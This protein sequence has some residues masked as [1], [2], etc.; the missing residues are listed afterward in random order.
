[1]CEPFVSI[2]SLEHTPFT[3]WTDEKVIAWCGQITE[4]VPKIARRIEFDALS[5]TTILPAAVD[6]EETSFKMRHVALADPEIIDKLPHALFNL[7]INYP[8]IIRAIGRDAARFAGVGDESGA[9]ALNNSN[10]RRV[11]AFATNQSNGESSDWHV[12]ER[13]TIPFY[14]ERATL[15]VS[16]L[17]NA[18]NVEDIL[19]HPMTRVDIDYGQFVIFDGVNHPHKG[20]CLSEQ[21]SRDRIV[22][23]FL[24]ETA[25]SEQNGPPI[26]DLLGV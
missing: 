15:L 26:D 10:Y 7:V 2:R 22:L 6:R 14:P 25:I 1:M 16:W 4:C 24:F 23:G 5:S 9:I 3:T 21:E 8:S 12:D 20:Y 17:R 19:S 13:L 11:E 18:R